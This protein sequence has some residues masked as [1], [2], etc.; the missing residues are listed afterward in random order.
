MTMQSEPTLRGGGCS[1][2]MRID[3]LGVLVAAWITAPSL[4]SVCNVP[5]IMIPQCEWIRWKKSAFACERKK[6]KGGEG[7][8]D[9]WADLKSSTQSSGSEARVCVL[10][11]NLVLCFGTCPSPV[12]SC[13]LVCVS[14]HVLVY[15]CCSGGLTVC[16]QA[17][18]KCSP[19]H[20]AFIRLTDKRTL[21][22][23]IRFT[24]NGE[25]SVCVCKV[26]CIPLFLLPLEFW[27]VF[28]VGW[29]DK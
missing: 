29:G 8:T 26:P 22:T 11:C 25:K 5:K 28:L 7:E 17:W 19:T 4:L 16:T 20:S 1:L 24:V 15:V 10:V 9:R 27:E 14:V 2:L 23:D 13:V 6:V 21:D 18:W 12:P 3:M